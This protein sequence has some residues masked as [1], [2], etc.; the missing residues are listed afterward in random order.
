MDR[1]YVPVEADLADLT[2]N[3]YWLRTHDEHAELIGKRGR[4]LAQSLTYERELSRAVIRIVE[5]MRF[6]RDEHRLIMGKAD[7]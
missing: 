6:F 2:E 5:S 7:S 3:I 1:P 4:A